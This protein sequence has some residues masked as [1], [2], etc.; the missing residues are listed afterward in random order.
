[1]GENRLNIRKISG[2]EEL[3]EKK[4]QSAISDTL[5]SEESKA[6]SVG[7]GREIEDKKLDKVKDFE[8]GKI[9]VFNFD[10]S[11]SCSSSSSHSLEMMNGYIEYP[12]SLEFPLILKLP[13]DIYLVSL[14]HKC[15]EGALGVDLNSEDSVCSSESSKV[16]SEIT[17]FRNPRL[18]AGSSLSLVLSVKDDSY[19]KGFSYTL[20]YSRKI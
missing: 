9:A 8:Q 5:S 3:I 2:L 4:I 18:K 7:L 1:M 19:P 20:V 17:C 6:V 13:F 12:E 11:L 15:S 16:L 14:S 10:G